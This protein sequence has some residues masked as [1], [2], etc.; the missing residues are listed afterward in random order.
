MTVVRF[1]HLIEP[2]VKP[3]AHV[4]DADGNVKALVQE[5]AQLFGQLN[6]AR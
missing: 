3:F 5:Q 1:L 4:P 6:G 2:I